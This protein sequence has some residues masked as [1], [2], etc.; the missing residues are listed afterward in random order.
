MYIYDGYET[1]MGLLR[2]KWEVISMSHYQNL[3]KQRKIIRNKF[4]GN[5]FLPPKKEN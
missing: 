1:Q 3:Q 5:N 2:N 4:K